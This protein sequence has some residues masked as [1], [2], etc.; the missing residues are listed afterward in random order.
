MV[1]G[2]ILLAEFAPPAGSWEEDRSGL[3]K[4]LAQRLAIDMRL[5][6]DRTSG[7]V[8]TWL[9]CCALDGPA[10]PPSV[11]FSAGPT[12]RVCDLYLGAHIALLR[13]VSRFQ[14]LLDVGEIGTM[15]VF[16]EAMEVFED[17]WCRKVGNPTGPV[18]TYRMHRIAFLVQYYKLVI[19]SRCLNQEPR[20]TQYGARFIATWQVAVSAVETAVT[21][22]APTGLLRY[23]P[24]SHLA[25]IAHACVILQSLQRPGANEAGEL[26]ARAASVLAANA[27]DAQHAPAV[28]SA[29]LAPGALGPAEAARWSASGCTLGAW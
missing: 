1:Q 3:F 10:P 21:R 14:D 11:D 8:R 19:F 26:I 25:P 7:A 9:V 2:Y 13:V 16:S 22:L 4:A 12:E 17:E 23:A 6:R 29:A 5:H 28:Y 24:A 20:D 18:S 27:E 15:K